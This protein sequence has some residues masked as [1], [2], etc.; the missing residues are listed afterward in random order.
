MPNYDLNELAGEEPEWEVADQID[1]AVRELHN[2]MV[3]RQPDEQ[4]PPKLAF[5]IGRCLGRLD[6]IKDSLRA[7]ARQRVQE[8]QTKDALA[9]ATSR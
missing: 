3:T 9:R 8:A 7:Q 6:Q 4:T 2:S 1:L 5:T